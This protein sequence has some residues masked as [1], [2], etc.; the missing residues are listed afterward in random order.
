VGSHYTRAPFRRLIDAHL[1]FSARSSGR[2]ALLSATSGSWFRGGSRRSSHRPCDRTTATS[3]LHTPGGAVRQRCGAVIL[4]RPARMSVITTTAAPMRRSGRRL[5]AG[6]AIGGGTRRRRAVLTPPP[7]LAAP[8][9]KHPRS[10]TTLRCCNRRLR[11]A[12]TTGAACFRAPA[13]V[14][15]DDRVRPDVRRDPCDAYGD[16]ACANGAVFGDER[17]ALRRARRV[18]HRCCDGHSTPASRVCRQYRASRP[19][20]WRLGPRDGVDRLA[21]REGCHRSGFA[22]K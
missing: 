21:A 5:I 9:L 13:V 18:P 2:P 16:G 10:A 8:P 20:L 14:R 7:L 12:R 22:V 3:Q 4:A 17:V 1:A 19:G 11:R 6:R 15:A